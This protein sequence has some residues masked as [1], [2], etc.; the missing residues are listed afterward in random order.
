[1]ENPKAK[2]RDSPV[3]H[4]GRV[5]AL[6][7][8]LLL[9]GN[10]SACQSA[11]SSQTFEIEGGQSA[12][13]YSGGNTAYVSLYRDASQDLKDGDFERAEATYRQIID[14][15]PDHA[16]GYIGLGTSLLLQ[17]RLDEAEVA[18]KEALTIKPDSVEALTGL[19]SVH[20][21]KEDYQKA[22]N[23]YRSAVSLESRNSNALWGLAISLNELGQ[24]GQALEYLG[25]IL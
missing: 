2:R 12:Y 18:Y 20:F 22:A 17:E 4:R 21:R 9:V 8:F 3:A 13:E 7:A 6:A 16:D 15:E 25:R 10:L 19:G 11:S 23:F 24:G 14:V 5:G 1:M